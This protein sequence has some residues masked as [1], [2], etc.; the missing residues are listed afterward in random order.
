MEKHLEK[1]PPEKIAVRKSLQKL[2]IQD[3]E[4]PRSFW[5]RLRH[6]LAPEKKARSS[7]DDPADKKSS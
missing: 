1:E 6:W 4:S 7:K 3:G 2:E 5:G